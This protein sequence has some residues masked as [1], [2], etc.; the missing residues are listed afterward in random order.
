MFNGKTVRLLT[1]IL[2]SF[3]L[4]LLPLITGCSKRPSDEELSKLEEAKMAALAAEKEV[5][6][7]KAERTDLEKELEKMQKE[8]NDLKAERDEVKEC[9]KSKQWER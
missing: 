8:L 3:S 6:A 4:L 1:L 9:V 5:E 2:V 7:K